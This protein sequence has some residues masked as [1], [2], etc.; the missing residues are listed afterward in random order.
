MLDLNS[1]YLVEASAGTGKTTCLVERIVQVLESERCEPRSIAAITYTRQAAGELRSRLRQHTLCQSLPFVGTIH[2]FCARLLREFPLE[3]G[4]TPNFRELDEVQEAA[5]LDQALR[6]AWPH[7]QDHR[8]DPSSLWPALRILQ[9]NGELEYPGGEDEYGRIMRFLQHVRKDY[10]EQRLRRGELCFLDLLQKALELADLPQVRE[11]YRLILVDE[12]QDTDPL[13][14]Q[15]LH[16]LTRDRPGSL[17][18]V[19][20]PKQSIYRFRRADMRSYQNFRKAW[21]DAGS[22]L[23]QLNH[24]RRCTPALCH[25]LNRAF[26]SLFPARPCPMQAHFTP[27]ISVRTPTM[28][29]P[30]YRMPCAQP[31]QEIQQV[32]AFILDRVRQ[33]SHNFGD[34]LVLTVRNHPIRL[35][36]ELFQQMGI[37]SQAPARRGPLGP[38]AASLLPLLRHLIDPQDKP[39]LV[40]VLRGPLFGHSDRELYQHVQQAGTL[41][42]YPLG[43]GLATVAASLQKLDDW[44]LV[45]RW[46]PPGAALAYLLEETGLTQ[47]A[48]REGNRA[49][50]EGLLD[51]MRRSGERG[52]TLAQSVEELMDQGA[53]SLPQTGV[54]RRD[55]VRLLTV[56]KAKG[57]EAR[58]VIL[59]SPR[60]GLSQRID[61]VVDDQRRGFVRLDKV[62]EPPGWSQLEAAEK[63]MAAAEHLRLLY[64][65]ATR[66]QETL[67]VG[68]AGRQSPWS[69]L[70]PFLDEAPL[71]PKVNLEPLPGSSAASTP[72]SKPVLE[73]S[74]R[75]VNIS[76]GRPLLKPTLVAEVAGLDARDWGHLLHSLL[77]RAADLPDLELVNWGRWYCRHQPRLLRALP[78]ALGIVHEVRRSPLGEWLRQSRQCLVEVPF[79]CRTG[80]RLRFGT[81]DLAIQR[82]DGWGLVDYKTDRQTVSVLATQYARQMAGYAQCWSLLCEQSPRYAGLFS[83]REMKLSIDLSPPGELETE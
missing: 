57:L 65:A 21:S 29:A 60:S 55:V 46:L 42:P 63:K 83:L 43:G 5:G 22:K 25:W 59:A 49:E 41:R 10:R 77:E 80:R 74:W 16:R 79:G 20:D 64:V 35:Y 52:L 50:L 26:E 11:R 8:L 24:T 28:A 33:G 2:A 38:M 17:F 36:Q 45:V 37:P 6:H 27:M 71:L 31:R 34:F 1:N 9:Q 54:G 12:F 58:V 56:H 81:I 18:L 51:S 73:P 53:V 15:L 13:Q 3:A 40:G 72:P 47:L 7:F 39:V 61:S 76:A 4:L 68:L 82:D 44:R 14:T 70:E 66:A 78:Q 75:K 48:Q 69:L 30:V 67:I 62:A 32:G 23:H 19:G